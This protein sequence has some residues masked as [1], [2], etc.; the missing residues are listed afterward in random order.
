ML[1]AEES[2]LAI[3][4]E[5]VALAPDVQ[6]VA[7]MQ[8]PV[9]DSRGNDGVVEKLSPLAEALDGGQDYRAPLL[10]SGHQGEES[11]GGGRVQVVGP[12]AKLVNDEHLGS[13]VDAHAVV[14]IVLGP[15]LP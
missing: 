14:Q 3:L 1:R 6:H 10:P 11:G 7:V 5:P 9:Q 2:S 4:A 15:C 13:Q 12:D 8:Q